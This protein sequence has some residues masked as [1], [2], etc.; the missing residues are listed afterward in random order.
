MKKKAYNMPSFLKNASLNAS[1]V[2]GNNFDH[3]SMISEYSS[4]V[5]LIFSSDRPKIEVIPVNDSEY[6]CDKDVPSNFFLI[7]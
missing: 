6:I 2:S 3:I 1:F 5:H 7:I 4:L